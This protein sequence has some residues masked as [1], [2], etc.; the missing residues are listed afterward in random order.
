LDSCEPGTT[1]A[2]SAGLAVQEQLDD[3]S[4]FVFAEQWLDRA[5]DS[6]VAANLESIADFKRV[7]ALEV[8]GRQNRVSAPKLVT[9][10]RHHLYNGRPA[11]TDR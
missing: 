6:G 3:E 11:T 8:A 10:I 4:L 1:V 2:R 7:C 5:D 9:V